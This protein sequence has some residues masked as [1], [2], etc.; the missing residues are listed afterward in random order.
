MRSLHTA[1]REKVHA[2]DSLQSKMKIQE[3]RMEQMYYNACHSHGYVSAGQSSMLNDHVNAFR[4]LINSL[5][6]SLLMDEP[7]NVELILEDMQSCVQHISQQSQLDKNL[8]AEIE[9]DHKTIKN[10]Q[11]YTCIAS[12]YNLLYDSFISKILVK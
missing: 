6:Y 4:W 11:F 7:L 2:I 8:F 3:H 5:R 12:R 10:T 9:E 1:I